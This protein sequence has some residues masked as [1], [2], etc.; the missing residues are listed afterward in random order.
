MAIKGDEIRHGQAIYLD[1]LTSSLIE[2]IGEENLSE[3]MLGQLTDGSTAYSPMS[4]QT[5]LQQ[6][7]AQGEVVFALRLQEDKRCIGAARLAHITWQAQYARIE[8]AIVLDE[9][10]T[11]SILQDVV[12]TV[13][14]FAFWEANLNRVAVHCIENHELLAE[15]LG[16]VGFTEEGR[17]RQHVYRDGQYLDKV[18]YSMLNREWVESES[19]E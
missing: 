9:F 12:Q 10:Y 19:A 18:V 14:Q 17:L 2:S 4:A 13:L 6:F 15:T 11:Q 5:Y 1:A 3:A 16:A 7:K 8:F